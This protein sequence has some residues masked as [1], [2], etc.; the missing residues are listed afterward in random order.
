M[1][2]QELEAIALQSVDLTQT[3]VSGIR[4]GECDCGDSDGN[5]GGCGDNG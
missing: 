4:R 1:N 2:L 3:S 5:D